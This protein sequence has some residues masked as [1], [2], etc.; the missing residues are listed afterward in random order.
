MKIVEV[1]TKRG[2][3]LYGCWYGEDFK[4]TCVIV[5]N[6]TGG[7]IFENKF[8][9]VLGDELEKEKFSYIY[10]HN[11]GA[12]HLIY[13]KTHNG[14]QGGMTTEL[15]DYCEEDLQAFIDFAKE[16]GYKK[17]ILAGHSYGANKVVYYLYKNPNEK[18]DKFILMSPVDMQNDTSSE[19]CENKYFEKTARKLIK[20]GKG[21]EI[22]PKLYDGYNFFTAESFLD[23]IENKN[24]RNLPIYQK[25]QDFS[26]LKSIKI[27][28][29]FVMGEKDGFAHGDTKKHLEIINENSYNKKNKIAVVKGAGHTFKNETTKEFTKIVINFVKK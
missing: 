12:F 14:K 5:T 13:T 6:G 2:T 16:Q 7:N 18:I 9:R 11:S 23:R 26:Q 3:L 24:M 29:L 8:L 15:F 4:D 28:G 10:A 27:P 21:S 22:I 17:I 19:Q 20:K 25:E 1:A